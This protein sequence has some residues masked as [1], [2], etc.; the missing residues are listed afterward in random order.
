MGVTTT[1]EIISFAESLIGETLSA[2]LAVNLANHAKDLIESDREWSFLIK[3]DATKTRTQ[4]DTYLTAKALPTDFVS[5]YK[6]ILG[7]AT[8]KDFIEYQSVPFHLRRKFNDINCYYIDYANSNLYVAG[9]VDKTYTIY[10][11]YIFQTPALDTS[12]ENPVWPVRFRKLIS[13]LMAKLYLSGIDYDEITARQAVA[14][15]TEAKMLYDSMCEW[16][17]RLKQKQLNGRTGFSGDMDTFRTDR[18][19]KT[20]L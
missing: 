20:N 17:S 19:D 2:T 9:T 16:D 12:S 18:V 14:D 11:Y 4:A 8:L 15:N 1:A 5:D 6:V 13:F 10:L 3:E 7:D